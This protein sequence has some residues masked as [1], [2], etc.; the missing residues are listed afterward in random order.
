LVRP[1]AVGPRDEKLAMASSSVLAPIVITSRAQPGE[2]TVRAL[3]PALPAATIMARPSATAA[4]QASERASV[5]SHEP[6][7]PRLMFTTATP[8]VIAHSTPAMTLLILPLP[9][10]SSTLPMYNSAAGATPR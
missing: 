6:S 3:G 4:S 7:L 5:P 8:C 9:R 10:S 2:P 1:S